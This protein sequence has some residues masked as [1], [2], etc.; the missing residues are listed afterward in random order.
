MAKRRKSPT[1]GSDPQERADE[2]MTYSTRFTPEQRATIDQA[3]GILNWSPAK[4]IR[5]ASIRRAA[6]VINASGPAQHR[7]G[8]LAYLVVKQLLAKRGMLL[9][10]N[11]QESMGVDQQIVHDYKSIEDHEGC[12]DKVVPVQ[13]PPEDLADILIWLEEAPT[14]FVRLI[15]DH[16][17]L[18]DEGADLIEPTVS[19]Y[20]LLSESEGGGNE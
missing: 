12:W 14:E 2:P 16:F 8:Q 13:L 9:T 15:I 10:Q 6:D 5:D 19:R 7:L 4:F 17:L 11:S 1:K 20:R 18:D 3:C